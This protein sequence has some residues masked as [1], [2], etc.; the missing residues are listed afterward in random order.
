[1]KGKGVMPLCCPTCDAP[2][3]VRRLRYG[4]AA[5]CKFHGIWFQR[6]VL[7]AA[8]QAIEN[9]Q[10]SIT[11]LNESDKVSWRYRKR[12][13]TQLLRLLESAQAAPAKG[14]IKCPQCKNPLSNCKVGT[15]QAYACVDDG[16]WL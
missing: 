8:V 10:P 11:Q 1:M 5:E 12:F 2:T 15:N 16:V 3:K 14:D 4:H 7:E 6:I 13:W 9:L